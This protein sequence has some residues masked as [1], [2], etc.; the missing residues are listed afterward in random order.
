MYESTHKRTNA[1]HI[2]ITMNKF[3]ICSETIEWKWLHL[4]WKH[5]N[6]IDYLVKLNR[7][8]REKM[9][10][11][12]LNTTTQNSHIHHENETYRCASHLPFVFGW[13]RNCLKYFTNSWF[14]TLPP[15][16]S[17]KFR[18]SAKDNS[19]GTTIFFFPQKQYQ[20]D[21]TLA[22]KWHMPS[23]THDQRT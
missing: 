7:F 13:V 21:L 23:T 12:T 10:N 6:L 19:L 11:K 18:I 1:Q 8:D 4:F 22:H 17:I 15:F 16:F 14:V 20:F 3:G 2:K 9:P 5:C